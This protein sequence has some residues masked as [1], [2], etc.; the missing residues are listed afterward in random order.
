MNQQWLL[1]DAVTDWCNRNDWYYEVLE[2][3]EAIRC[4]FNGDNARFILLISVHGERVMVRSVAPINVPSNK[5]PVI[6]ELLTRANYGLA[7][8]NFEMDFRDGEVSF[9]TSTT[10]G[11][12]PM[13]DWLIQ[14]LIFINCLM[15]DKYFPAIMQTI[16]SEVDPVTALAAVES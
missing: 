12:E 10:T 11:S 1:Y 3:G 9:K 13:P 16:Y 15:M 8:G 4:G 5:R 7:I 6:A 2:E 14:D